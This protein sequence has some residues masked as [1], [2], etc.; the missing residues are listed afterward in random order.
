[1]TFKY[2]AEAIRRI[3][4]INEQLPADRKI[5]VISISYGWELGQGGF[6]EVTQAAQAAKDAGLLVISSS[7]EMTHGFKFHGLGR[8]L[9]VFSG[10]LRLVPAGAVG[11]RS[12]MRSTITCW[13]PW[14]RALTASP[15]G[16]NEYAF[17]AE[18]GWSWAIPYIA[19][20]FAL[21]AQVDPKITPERFWNLAL[22]TGR[23]IEVKD[24]RQDHLPGSHSRPRPVDR[25]PRDAVNCGDSN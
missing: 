10:R 21:A 18:G 12:C 19:G 25:C 3:L 9:G 24:A 4:Q 23:T 5:R 7:V 16:K 11:G 20:T 6:L 15:T 17:Y 22:K 2:D 8:D 1:M 13:S 14:M